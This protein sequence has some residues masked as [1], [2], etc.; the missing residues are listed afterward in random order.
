MAKYRSKFFLEIPKVKN[1]VPG[2]SCPHVLWSQGSGWARGVG[3]RGDSETAGGRCC[4]LKEGPTDGIWCCHIPWNDV[5][6]GS[7]TLQLLLLQ[8]TECVWLSSLSTEKPPSPAKLSLERFTDFNPLNI[9]RLVLSAIYHKVSFSPFR[10]HGCSLYCV[11]KEREENMSYVLIWTFMHFQSTLSL[12]C[13]SLKCEGEW[14][15]VWLNCKQVIGCVPLGEESL[16]VKDTLAAISSVS[17]VARGTST[18]TQVGPVPKMLLSSRKKEN[19]SS[20]PVDSSRLP[21][22][23][24]PGRAAVHSSSPSGGN[25]CV[26]CSVSLCFLL[27]RYL[28]VTTRW[29]VQNNV[30]LVINQ[31]CGWR[32]ST[33]ITMKAQPAN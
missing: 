23:C 30:A 7:L 2:L 21:W 6:R 26:S 33:N 3:C 5:R 16:V 19:A 13:F 17:L 27:L 10:D 12:L 9:P 18:V 14:F 32:K 29:F 20:S 15:L 8:L 4:G 11:I 25:N 1:D 31:T 28:S 24:T 22:C